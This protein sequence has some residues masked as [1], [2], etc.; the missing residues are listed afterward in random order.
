MMVINGQAQA[1]RRDDVHAS[2]MRH[3]AERAEANPAQSLVVW[4]ADNDDADRFCL[5]EFY[6]NP[7]QAAENA[8][9]DWFWA[10]M[11]EVGPLL[12]GE[13]TVQ[14]LTPLWTKGV[15]A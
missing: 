5:V 10:Y 6:K 13:P 14:N 1:G 11:A 4:A 7:A 2:F 12:A 3:L 9:A 8:Q 15:P